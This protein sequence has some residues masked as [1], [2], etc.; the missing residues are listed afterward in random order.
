MKSAG[1]LVVLLGMDNHLVVE[2]GDAVLVCPVGKT[3]SIRC[4]VQEL[5]R[6]KMKAY[7]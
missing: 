1:K 6:K 4:I 5:Q 3:Q 2:T 7:L